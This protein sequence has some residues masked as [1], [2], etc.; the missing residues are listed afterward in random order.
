ME[1]YEQIQRLS[2]QGFTGANVLAF[3][4]REEDNT[5]LMYNSK[6]TAAFAA[7]LLTVSFVYPINHI[8]SVKRG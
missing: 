8:I 1:K 5:D 2:K 3:A 6:T 4:S 7:A